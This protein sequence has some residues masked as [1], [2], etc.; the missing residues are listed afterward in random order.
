MRHQVAPRFR[1]LLPLAVAL[2]L[3]MS[4]VGTL[5][6]AFAAA[7]ALAITT[8][9]SGAVS[10]VAF[11]QQPVIG[12]VDTATTTVTSDTTTVVTAAIAS[13]SGTL[14]GT[15]TAT[16]VNGVVTF[17]NLTITGAGAY[18]LIFNSP[19]LTSA[20]SA[21]FT[22]TAAT[23]YARTDGSDANCDGTM[24]AAY[25]GTGSGLACAKA[26][27]QAAIDAAAPGGTVNVAAGT[28]TLNSQLRIIQG[29]D[30]RGAG[31]S[32][33]ITPGTTLWTNTSGSKGL[34]S[35]ITITA[36]SEVVTLENLKVTGAKNIT[37]TSSGTDYGHG[38][39]VFNSSN[40][41]LTNVTSTSNQ[42]A[43]LV[44]NGSTVTAYNLNTSGNGW[45]AVNVDP[46]S[47]VT[48]ASVFRIISGNLAEATQ[49]WSDGNH[50]T[51]TA[52][53]IVSASGYSQ[54]KVGGTTAGYLWTNRALSNA[55]TIT[56]NG[57][58]TL[59]STIMSAVIA[60]Q[61]GDTI[62]VAPGDYNLIKD[63]TTVISGETGWYLPITKNNI[64]LVG[65]NANGNEITN[66][67]DVA[68]NI[69]STQETA[70]GNWSTQNLITVF[71]DNVTIQG[72]GIMNKISPNKA[73]EVLG[74][75][76]KAEDNLFLPVPI[77]LFATANNYGGDDI[78]KYGSGVYLNNNG[79]TT[80]RT[81]TIT[82]NIF[83]NSG[84]TFDSFKN[85]WTVD[86]SN[87]V[88][89]GN[90]IWKSGGVDYYFSTVGS[91]TWANQPDFTGSTI[92]IHNNKFINMVIDKPFLK[93]KADMT[94]S[95]NA[96]NNY[97]DSAVLATIQG[98]VSGLVTVVPYFV[99]SSLTT[100]NT[101]APSSVYVNTTY[102]DGSV[103]GHIFGYDAFATIQG[104]VNAVASGGTI[105]VAPGTYTE[106][107]TINN[108]VHLLGPN[109][110]TNPNIATRSAEAILTGQITDYAGNTDVKG[111]TITN[112]NWSGATIK[113]IHVY[114]AG[115][116]ISN[117]TLQNN[118]FIDINNAVA[119][120]SYGVMVQ[121][122]TSGVSILDNKF[123]NISSAGW[124]HAIEVT[125]TSNSSAVPQNTTI[126]G[127]AISNITNPS[128]SDAY[129]FS[130]DSATNNSNPIYAD[131]SQITFHQNSLLGNVRNLDPN[132][133]LDATNNWW[134]SA[135][136]PG[137][138][139]RITTA[140]WCTD[141]TCST[142]SNN[143]DLTALSL[144]GGSL[145]PAFSSSVTIYAASVENGTTSVTV[146]ATTN[147]G[148][149]AVVTG[150]SLGYGDNTVTITVTSADGSATKTYTVTVTRFAP[151]EVTP[152][153]PEVTPAPPEVT[154]APPIASIEKPVTEV[155]KADA[156]KET[157]V[158]ATIET[159]G[160][161][162]LAVSVI[163][164]VGA[165]SKDVK[166]SIAPAVTST[167][168]AAGLV[169]IKVLVTD[170]A[171]LPITKFDKP[172][173]LN[174]GKVA[175]GTTAAFS[176]DGIVWT[177]IQLLSGTT[178]PD[179]V[180]EGYYAAADGGIVI[181]T[182][183]LTYFGVKKVQSVLAVTSSAVTMNVGTSS[184]LTASGGSGDG[185]AGFM[186]TTPAVC[187]VSSAGLVAALSA[188]DCT[189]V[190]TKGGNGTYLDVSSSPLS[191]TIQSM[192]RAVVKTVTATG[193]GS[194]RQ[195]TVTF[196]AAYA[197]KQIVLQVRKA[198]SLKYLTF[199][200][201]KLNK[202]GR[203]TTRRTVPAKS[204]IRVLVS[205]RS[206]AAVRL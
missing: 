60:S 99:D 65:I 164:P 167:E 89:D 62:K 102:T 198:G 4:I 28:Y 136:G 23:L 52:T 183:H 132:H 188:G 33:I 73:I 6:S 169:T 1:I 36:G 79:A 44:V 117:I 199:A 86:I 163:I 149:N 127:N 21:S 82:N 158:D 177:A 130:V 40:V 202:A 191:L 145:N 170:S 20:T 129:A 75:N 80:A 50:V 56:K 22:V 11:T 61:D 206:Q 63:D 25:P 181:L 201:V 100:L 9:P 95:Y 47:G 187:W 189:V 165:I 196:G 64:T 2:S 171:G 58:T 193:K 144:T 205:G 72:L 37:M 38:I 39:N 173:V 172:L 192:V 14:S 68:T 98:Q 120:G 76:F 105:N 94:G 142:M 152:A 115:T 108:P 109:A 51:S 16:A 194:W 139:T 157:T 84:V 17:N 161:T 138:L 31:D 8:E 146:S 90:K 123:D 66:A 42:A 119:H 116:L 197:N 134:G 10:G 26:T 87:N 185:V 121:G 70:N 3:L 112:P 88:F 150:G 96:T 24:N 122:V 155:A 83:K 106:N 141:A 147:P 176:Q 74:N 203:V 85:N 174:L 15:Q 204:T 162:N 59:Y 103:G 45:G 18:T 178:L 200:K 93:I 107:L 186:T 41:A 48:S 30:I 101:V 160:T 125:P 81:A 128:Q 43:G 131:A 46:G 113:G 153:P 148:A 182:R 111:F 133:A 27:I 69:Y 53:V 19:S 143:A 34:A 5:P 168:A 77:R 151:P 12:I 179:G 97:W 126:T 29:V 114:N 137:S 91:T 54:Y 92:N 124:A 190:A 154:P 140:P 156:T 184:T 35:L 104:G 13:G 110:T 71:G 7:S 57:V 166:V 135:S 195:I 118:I 55:A 180:Q 67:V 78:T 175:T 159:G 49:I 32:T